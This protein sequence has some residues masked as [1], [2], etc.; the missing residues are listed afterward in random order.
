MSQRK[1]RGNPRSGRT[2]DVPIPTTDIPDVAA[3][4]PNPVASVQTQAAVAA[5]APAIPMI[6]VVP[7]TLA[8]AIA[9]GNSTPTQAIAPKIENFGR[10][11]D[12]KAL[13]KNLQPKAFT[14]EGS[15]I[16]K[17]LKEWLM[18][19]DDYFALAEYNA[20]A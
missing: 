4:V 2:A 12:L 10:D 8:M 9:F 7:N 17:H 16:P 11:K 15:D 18:S 14:G 13:L 3:T 20:I 6:A 19:M 1:T 5:P